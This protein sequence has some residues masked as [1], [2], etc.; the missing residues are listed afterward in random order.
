MKQVM[1]LSS[2]ET[3]SYMDSVSD[4]IS[5]CQSFCIANDLSDWLSNKLYKG[6]E[7]ACFLPIVEGKKTIACGDWSIVKTVVTGNCQGALSSEAKDDIKILLTA[8]MQKWK[9]EAIQEGIDHNGIDCEYLELTIATND[10]G[11][12]FNFQTGDNSIAGNCY[13]LPHWSVTYIYIDTDAEKLHGQ[14]VDE[15]ESLLPENR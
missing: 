4:L 5:V 3:H 2:N 8:N 14:I 1:N 11:D 13:S 15:L 9:R 6:K 10:Q 7:F 12:R